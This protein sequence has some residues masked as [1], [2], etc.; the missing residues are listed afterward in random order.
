MFIIIVTIF[1]FCWLPYHLFFIVAFHNKRLTANVFGQQ[2]YLAF[3][4]LAMS[5]AMV[6][7]L[8]YYWMNSRFRVY[9]QKI[10]CFC[11][12]GCLK[13]SRRKRTSGILMNKQ[14]HSHSDQL[15]SKSGKCP[16]CNKIFDIAQI[17]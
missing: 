1:G 12:I 8:I 15:R 3:Y 16:T 2:L 17:G 13:T 14:M 11:C 5:N 6:N 9:F 4:W 7:P 10:V